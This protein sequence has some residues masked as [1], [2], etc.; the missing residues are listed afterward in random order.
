[1]DFNQRNVTMNRFGC[2][3][4]EDVC[5]VHHRPLTCRHGCVHVKGHACK[6]QDERLVRALAELLES[7][8]I[9]D[10]AHWKV[11]EAAEAL[12]EVKKRSER[13]IT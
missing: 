7:E 8:L 3:P 1:M 5:G 11:I 6:D 10:R 2:A 13:T 9:Q 4:N 12:A